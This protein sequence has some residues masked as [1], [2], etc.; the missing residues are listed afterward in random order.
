MLQIRKGVFETNSSS[1]HSLAV[2]QNFDTDKLKKRKLTFHLGSFAR[3]TRTHKAKP[4]DYLY[5]A[6]MNELPYFEYECYPDEK[7]REKVLNSD[8]TPDWKTLCP[9]ITEKLS[10]LKKILDS[11]NIKYEFEEPVWEKDS[12][13]WKTHSFIRAEKYGKKVCYIMTDFK[14]KK[15]RNYFI[16]RQFGIDHPEELS[17]IVDMLL[18]NPE[19]CIKF[20]LGGMVFV[21]SDE[22]DYLQCAKV[23]WNE[24]TYTETY[25]FDTKKNKEVKRYNRNIEYRE[26]EHVNPYYMEGYNYYYKGN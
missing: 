6:I 24:K 13:S 25:Y 20:L 26:R 22:A 1:T 3:P 16:N 18:S 8:L 15:I 5:T 23:H 11:Y 21:G 17:S 12:E 10:K 9:K 7:E 2:P 4:T 19:E 14:G